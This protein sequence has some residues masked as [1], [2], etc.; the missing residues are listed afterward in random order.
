VVVALSWCIVAWR[1][2]PRARGSGC[3]SFN[4]PWCFTLT[5]H[6]SSFSARSLI[7]TA[8]AVYVCVP[9]AILGS[10]LGSVFQSSL[11]ICLSIWTLRTFTFSVN[12]ERYLLFPILL[13]SLLFSFT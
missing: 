12:I 9:F 10:H 4:S 1:R 8:H 7:H 6:G 3:Q 5:K 2:L 13:V 11:L